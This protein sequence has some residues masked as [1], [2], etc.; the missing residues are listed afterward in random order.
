VDFDRD[1]G[2]TLFRDAADDLSG[3]ERAL[4]CTRQKVDLE[5]LPCAIRLFTQVNRAGD[6]AVAATPWMAGW[7]PSGRCRPPLRSRTFL[8]T[9]VSSV[10]SL[11]N[12]IGVV[13]VVII[14]TPRASSG[15]CAMAG[16][17]TATSSEASRNSPL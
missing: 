7:T 10:G 1:A 17:A 12:V 6:G 4:L 13:A 3:R 8:L 5:V 9:Y 15:L 11:I 2:D 16:M 14:D